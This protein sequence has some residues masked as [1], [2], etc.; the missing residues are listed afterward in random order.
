MSKEICHSP[1]RR[2][3]QKKGENIEWLYSELCLKPG[4]E[5]LLIFIDFPS[6][7]LSWLF[8]SHY[9]IL[10]QNSESTSRN[11]HCTSEKKLFD[12]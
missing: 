6:A 11:P 1:F 7:E 12:T 2:E 5:F 9:K 8:S 3:L 4:Q 10:D